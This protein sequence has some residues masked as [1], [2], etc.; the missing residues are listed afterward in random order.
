MPVR[1]V[2]LP[3]YRS[4]KVAQKNLQRLCRRSCSSSLGCCSWEG[5]GEEGEER[6]REEKTHRFEICGWGRNPNTIRE[7]KRES[8]KKNTGWKMSS[9]G[10]VWGER[11]SKEEP[12][13]SISCDL[14]NLFNSDRSCSFPDTSRS[15]SSVLT[16]SRDKWLLTYANRTVLDRT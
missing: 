3:G 11:S 2:N 13:P 16:G 14:H 10:K 6:Q 7:G 15:S 9:D 1:S 8:M 4:E 12:C 5:R